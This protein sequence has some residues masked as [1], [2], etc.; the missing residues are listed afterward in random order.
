MTLP[1]PVLRR[2]LI[3]LGRRLV[4]VGILESAE[5]VFHLRFEELERVDGAWPPPAELAD[6][7][8]KAARRR[9]VDAATAWQ[10]RHSWI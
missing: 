3:E 9:A 8:R 10:I 1:M 6:E 4:E 2:T 5:D 7:L